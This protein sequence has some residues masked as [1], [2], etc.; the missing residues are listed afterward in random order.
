VADSEDGH[1][2][3]VGAQRQPAGVLAVQRD[4]GGA[5]ARRTADPR[6]TVVGGCAGGGRRAA[7]AIA[8]GVDGAHCWEIRRVQLPGIP[9][10]SSD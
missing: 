8:E 9:A 10:S 1:L 3:H 2:E 5:A 4:P 7:A 6:P